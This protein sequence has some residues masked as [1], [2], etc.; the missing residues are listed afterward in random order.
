MSIST[1]YR[2]K[3]VRYSVTSYNSCMPC[4]HSHSDP[5]SSKPP[6]PRLLADAAL[7]PPPCPSIDNA[8]S[9]ALCLAISLAAC[10][11]S[12][13]HRRR[14][15][16]ASPICFISLACKSCSHCACSFDACESRPRSSATSKATFSRLRFSASRDM[17]D[18]SAFCRKSARICC[19]CRTVCSSSSSFFSCLRRSSLLRCLSS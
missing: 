5:P 3:A 16:I 13:L 2:A 9:A 15:S 18:C 19:R 6:K 10:G 17:T 1:T 11:F 8:A 14:S 4:L 12:F 7:P